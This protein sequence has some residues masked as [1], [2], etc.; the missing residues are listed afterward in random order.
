MREQMKGITLVLF[1]ILLCC[2]EQGLNRTLF[3]TTSDVPFSLL[4]VIFGSSGLF[5]VFRNKPNE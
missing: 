2:A 1:G 4:G 5:L 3:T